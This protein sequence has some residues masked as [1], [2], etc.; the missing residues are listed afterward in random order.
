MEKSAHVPHVLHVLKAF[1]HMLHV[2]RPKKGAKFKMKIPFA[3]SFH[4]TCIWLFK[5]RPSIA[6]KGGAW[7]M[8]FSRLI[9][10]EL[11]SKLCQFCSLSPTSLG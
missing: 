1:Q 5:F 4:F 7:F 2:L 9:Y 10:S 3:F 6:I 11:L 8:N